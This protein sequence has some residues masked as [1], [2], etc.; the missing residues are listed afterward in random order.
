MS[1]YALKKL[2]PGSIEAALAKA[3]HYR[4]LNQPEEAESICRDILDVEPD[5]QSAWRTYVLALTDRLQTRDIGLL[6]DALAAIAKLKDEY[7]RA[8]YAGIAWE[9]AGKGHLDK[10]E[11]HSALASFEHALALFA[12]AE[13]L[14][15]TSPDPLLRWNR[16]VRILESN[17]ALKAAIDAPH[18]ASVRLGD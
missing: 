3:A 17:A 11:A 9:R 6:E 10:R 18:A 14:R 2:L 13:K 7:D 16:C 1:V 8:Y 15:P 5:N 12:E 4:D